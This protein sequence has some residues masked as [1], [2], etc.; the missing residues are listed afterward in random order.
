MGDLPGKGLPDLT[1]VPRVGEA[2]G[3]KYVIERIL[4]VGGMGVVA[5]ARHE[6]LGDEVAFKFLLPEEAKDK[7]SVARFLREARACVAIKSEHVVRVMD[8]AQLDTGLP[9]ILMEL[10]HGQDLSDLLRDKRELAVVDV[11]DYVLQA[12]IALAEAHARGIVHRDLKP[13]NLFLTRRSDGTPLVKILDFGISKSIVIPE[14]GEPSTLTTTRSMIG[15]PMYMSPEQV[16][17]AKLVD[18]RTDIWSLGVILYEL[19]TGKLP[20]DAE[21]ASGILAAVVADTPVPLRIRRPDAPPELEAVVARC[22]A[23]D[24]SGRVQSVLDLARAL[25]PFGSADAKLSF[26]RIERLTRPG[27]LPGRTLAPRPSL[28]PQGIANT[29]KGWTLAT[30]SKGG[31]AALLVAVGALAGVGVSVAVLRQPRRAPAP[32]VLTGPSARHAATTA[33]EA[34]PAS[35]ESPATALASAAAAAVTTPAVS[36]SAVPAIQ[37][38]NFPVARPQPSAPPPAASSARAAPT[39]P[40]PLDPFGSSH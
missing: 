39:P 10:L 1:G 23:K 37:R 26:E 34:E 2:V 12:C 19:M 33:T 21:T 30:R 20:F 4:G 9:F 3:G 29:I 7:D 16:R 40:P 38:P 14:G 31:M 24:P 17:N 22:L 36:A 8:V 18:E 6:A 27:A 25:Y 11:V 28:A 13:S 32:I 35:V 15:S 5:S